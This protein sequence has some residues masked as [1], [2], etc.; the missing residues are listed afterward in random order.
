MKKTCFVITGYGVK[1]DL[2][3]GKDYNLDNTY[4]NI[5]CLFNLSFF[6]KL[7]APIIGY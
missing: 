1:T 3:T 4:K 2:Q 5:I 6:F 7:I